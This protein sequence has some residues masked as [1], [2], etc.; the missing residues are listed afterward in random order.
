MDKQA[1]LVSL[2]K[3]LSGLPRNEV[4]GRLT[5][6]SEMIDDRME[7]GLSEEE[8]VA[9]AGSVDEIVWQI[10]D[11]VPF[12]KI[13]K[14]KIK[15]QRRLR[16]WEIVL[17]A[18]GSPIW[19]SLLVAA[20]AVIISVYV[21]MWSAIVSL[22]AVFASLIGCA[23]GATIGGAGFA[24]GGF[25]ATGMALVGVGSVCAGLAIFLFFGCK[26]ATKGISILTKRCAFG[27]KKRFV[28]KE[29]A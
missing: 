10:I 13:A 9:A 26:A 29:G 3:E 5:F 19:L 2:R 11:E 20:I 23:F 25:G 21:V 28:K 6:Y 4:E 22:W 1:F 15:A 12:K 14:E 16:A 17:L 7:E 8:A 18:L 24:V 27:I